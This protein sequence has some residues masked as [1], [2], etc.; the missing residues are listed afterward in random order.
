MRRILLTVLI[1]FAGLFSK[2]QDK[3]E[4]ADS[5]VRLMSAQQ[6]ELTQERGRNIRKVYGPAR[7]LH[8]GTYLLCDTAYWDVDLRVIKA[9][10]HVKILQ[11]ETVLSSE[12][13][14][15]LIDDNLAMFR[16]TLVQ[17]QDKDGNTLRTRNLDYNTKDSLAIFRNGGAMRDKDGQL[18]ESDTGKYDSKTKIFDFTDNVNMFT[19]SV[20]IKTGKLKYYSEQNVAYFMEGVDIWRNADMLSAGSGRYDRQEETFHFYKNVHGMSD[21]Q[22]GWADTLAFCKLTGDMELHGNI[23]LTDE[24]RRLWSFGENA[25][26]VDS[27]DRLVMSVDATIIAEIKEEQQ[28]Q[29]AKIDTLFM[30]ADSIVRRSFRKCDVDSMEVVRANKRLE[31]ISIDP[32]SEYR[33]KAAEEA[34]KAAED[35]QKEID[36]QMGKKPAGGGLKSGDEAKPA[37]AEQKKPGAIAEA[38]EENEGD[39]ENPPEKSGDDGED[40]PEKTGDGEGEKDKEPEEVKEPLDTTAVNFLEAIGKVRIFKSDI[41]ARCDSLAY[42]DL[43]SLA[44]LYIEPLV[45]NETNRQYAADSLFLQIVNQKLK[46][47]SFQSNAFITIQEDSLQFDQIRGTEMTAYFDTTTALERFDAM[48]GA[49]AVFYLEENEVLATVNKVES[50]MLSAYFEKGQIDRIYYFDSPK[51][52]AYPTAQL[53]GEDK[54]MKG[55]KWN[56]ELRPAGK[57]D[58]TPYSIRLSQ[59]HEYESRPEAAFRQTELYFPG[60]MKQVRASLLAREQARIRSRHLRDSLA[61][62]ERAAADSAANVASIRG[63]VVDAGEVKADAD[64]VS[65]LPGGSLKASSDSVAHPKPFLP[66]KDSLGRALPDSLSASALPDSLSTAALPDSLSAAKAASVPDSLSAGGTS[67]AAPELSPE[68]LKKLAAERKRAERDSLAA[69]RQ[70]KREARWA[71]L[72]ARDAEK[73]AIK[74]AKKQER[75]RKMVAKKLVI[76]DRNQA[77]EQ[78]YL[79]RY[80]EKYRKQ[81]ERRD[82]RRAEKASKNK[83]RRNALLAK[84]AYENQQEDNGNSET[85]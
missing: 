52:D 15:Y 13:L 74:A 62:N 84:K 59:R 46:K 65:A 49:S 82:A 18:V 76:R 47:A 30:A 43:D 54:Q 3:R 35:K 40:Q 2:A 1:L 6:A 21:R 58:I 64:S 34:K 5:L 66:G 7:F 45:W 79:E 68:E 22:E 75:Y 11:D 80:L 9:I 69:A 25:W 70:A 42:T 32:V 56:P 63:P 24:Q 41:Q 23:Q 31:D 71:E 17:L 85:Q 14:D 72:D 12:K 39:G 26:Y 55:F 53:R 61:L 27:L 20:F 37:T 16:G 28:G 57:D 29:R 36:E 77:R 67:P 51:N 4:P 50:K 10:G 44:R 81:K 38:G 78:K 83:E 33:R 48:G 60:Y 19:D 73:E 8:N